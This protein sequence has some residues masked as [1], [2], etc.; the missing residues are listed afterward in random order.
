MTSSPLA[1]AAAAAAA[2]ASGATPTPQATP[3][4]SGMIGLNGND[5]MTLLVA[6]LKNQDP[7]N[8]MDPTQFVTQL[9]QFNSLEQLISINQ[10]LTP[11][12]APTNPTNPTNPTTGGT[13]AP[14]HS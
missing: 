11:T 1:S 8:P 7:T 12:T 5:F 6:Q 3:N 4:A 2:A 10:D 14:A 13:A 9:V